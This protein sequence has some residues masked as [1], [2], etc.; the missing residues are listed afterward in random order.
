MDLTADTKK[1]DPQKADLSLRLI[2][3]HKLDVSATLVQALQ[4][5]GPVDF[6]ALILNDLG[7]FFTDCDVGYY[8]FFSKAAHRYALLKD[9]EFAD[10]V[11]RV[12][13]DVK[14]KLY[15]V[16]ENNEPMSFRR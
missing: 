7:D 12:L 15:P 4:N 3:F 8:D 1:S 10:L 16:S 2:D 5:K 9:A 14:N 6:S 11:Q 13:M